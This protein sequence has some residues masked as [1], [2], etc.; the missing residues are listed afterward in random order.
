MI[1]SGTIHVGIARH[2][3]DFFQPI[4]WHQSLK[5]IALMR[6][7]GYWDFMLRGLELE[8]AVAA[9]LNIGNRCRGRWRSPGGMALADIINRLR[10]STEDAVQELAAVLDVDPVARGG[11]IVAV[12][13]HAI[14]HEVSLRQ[15]VLRGT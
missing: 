5:A 10:S 2:P 7:T 6:L 4:R 12:M 3:D 11:N 1:R 13:T 9:G 15:R 14:S 8:V